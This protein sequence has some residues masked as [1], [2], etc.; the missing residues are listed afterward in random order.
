MAVRYSDRQLQTLGVKG[1]ATVRADALVVATG[2]RPAT[3]GELRIAGARC[4][5]VVS[6]PVALHLT[7]AGVLLG[8]S[9]VI[10]GGGQLAAQCSGLM[11]HAGAQRVTVVAP[12]GLLTEFPSG[13]QIHEG[14][15]ITS[16]SGS[17]GRVTSGCRRWIHPG[18]TIS[19]DAVILPFQRRPTRNIGGRRFR[20]CKRGVPSERRS[21]A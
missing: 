20:R 2:T 12:E 13:V 10:L 3:R 19:C 5:G 16:I 17:L 9:P 1:A 18:E 6:G 8:R 21:E 11:L 7:V 14:W 4:A 15:M